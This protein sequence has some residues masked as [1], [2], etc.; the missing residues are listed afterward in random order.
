[1]VEWGKTFDTYQL[2]SIANTNDGG[3]IIT[4]E[5]GTIKTDAFGNIQ[6]EKPSI[7]GENVIQTQDNGYLILYSTTATKLTNT[8]DLIWENT[9]GIYGQCAIE[10]LSSEG[11]CVIGG[12]N[13]FGYGTETAA[14]KISK[15]G[16]VGWL[17][18]YG[19]INEYLHR[20]TSIIH[21]GN[22]GFMMAGYYNSV[23]NITSDG[24][25]KFLNNTPGGSWYPSQVIQSPNGFVYGGT[26]GY[27]FAN[28]WL[29]EIDHQGKQLRNKIIEQQPNYFFIGFT[30]SSDGD[31]VIGGLYMG[32]NC[33]FSLSA[34]KVRFD[35]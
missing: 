29:V 20:Y 28:C 22:G 30:P 4:G 6:W 8:G 15:D 31:F 1:L 32:E 33:G 23:C 10:V 7:E 3:Y 18:T 21:D 2:S 19:N 17:K 14:V 5:S 9:I 13:G 11:A 25:L 27:G 35:D 26:I 24:A 16:E 12:L 34:A